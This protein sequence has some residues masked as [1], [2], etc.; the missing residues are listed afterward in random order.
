MFAKAYALA[1][2]F[3]QPLI[4]SIRLYDRSVKCTGGAFIVLNEEGWIMTA[5]H[6][7]QSFRAFQQHTREREAYEKQ[8]QAIEQDQ[9]LTMKQRSRKLR[10][11][12]PNPAWVTNHSFWWAWD[13]V[14][15]KEVRALA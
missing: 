3:T 7:W 9:S 14:S 13:D 10:E 5:A 2:C 15:I 11:F 6:L 1:S 12:K 8:L 4:V